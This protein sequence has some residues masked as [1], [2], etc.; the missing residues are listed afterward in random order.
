M[1]NDW[2]EKTSGLIDDVGQTF[3]MRVGQVPLKGRWLDRINRQ[4]RNQN[5]MAAEWLKSSGSR[6]EFG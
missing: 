3:V 4:N 5:R 2:I 1:C 6:P